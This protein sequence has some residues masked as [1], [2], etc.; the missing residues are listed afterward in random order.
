MKRQRSW[1]KQKQTTT[2]SPLVAPPSLSTF[3][4][5]IIIVNHLRPSS[6]VPFHSG[7]FPMPPSPPVLRHPDSSS[8]FFS[9][10]AGCG[11]RQEEWR[12]DHKWVVFHVAAFLMVSVAAVL[13]VASCCRQWMDTC[14]ELPPFLSF[15]SSLLLTGQ[16]ASLF[17]YIWLCRLSRNLL[18]TL[19]GHKGMNTAHWLSLSLYP[20]M[21]MEQ[22]SASA[23]AR[24][25]GLTPEARH[26]TINRARTSVWANL[27]KHPL[28]SLLES[29]ETV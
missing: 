22:A 10:I 6:G 20:N 17:L 5:I 26:D 8:Y 4:I 2:F 16:D 7:G 18:R 13:I 23:T 24:T 21:L 11:A 25:P 1:A 19:K 28:R 29:L 15:L 3:V 9:S 12:S 27:L 14:T